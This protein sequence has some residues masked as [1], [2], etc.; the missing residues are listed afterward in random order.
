MLK[1]IVTCD[2]CGKSAD[3]HETE[4]WYSLSRNVDL[5]VNSRRLIDSAE[6][7][8][9]IVCMHCKFRLAQLYDNAKKR[10]LKITKALKT[11]YQQYQNKELPDDEIPF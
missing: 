11:L 7:A 3:L 10:D 2:L 9:M 5:G 1:Q 4:W 8:G 6:F